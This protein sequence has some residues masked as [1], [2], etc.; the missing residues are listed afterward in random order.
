M[1]IYQLFIILFIL[2]PSLLQAQDHHEESPRHLALPNHLSLFIG[3]SD[4]LKGH[5]GPKVGFEYVR[6][7]SEL[8]ELRCALDYT[9][10]DY[11]DYS[12]SLNIDFF[13]FKHM[14]LYAG[15]GLGAKHNIE[16]W[17]FFTRLIT[18]YDFH[19]GVFSIGPMLMYDIYENKNYF[20]AGLGFGFGF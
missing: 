4:D 6:R 17:H 12:F 1:K 20:T 19:I 8:I 16:N 15:I 11:E 18:G 2:A 5:V 9:G 10:K 14:P 13:P 7:M 3:Y